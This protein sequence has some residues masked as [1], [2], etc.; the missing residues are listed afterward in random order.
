[1]ISFKANYFKKG[2]K[3]ILLLLIIISSNSYSQEH[4]LDFKLKQAFKKS[5]DTIYV[6]FTPTLLSSSDKIRKIK[7][8]NNLEFDIQ[9]ELKEK[10]HY[11]KYK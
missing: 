7:D 3:T 1:M 5:K 6:S 10:Y 2:F 11:F 9:E 4:A 8:F